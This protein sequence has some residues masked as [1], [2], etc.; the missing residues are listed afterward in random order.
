M[1]IRRLGWAGIEITAQDGTS[2]VVDYVRD[3]WLLPASQHPDQYAAAT[4]P[5][6]AALVT[7]LHDDHTDVGAI[8]SAV[9]PNGLLLR[10]AP[11]DASAEEA[12]LVEKPEA[13][14][15]DSVLNVRVVAEWERVEVGPFG[16]TAVPAVDGLGEA[17]VNWVV[18]AD[19]QRVFHGGDTMFHGFWWL[20]T[21]RAGPIDVA[22]LPINGPVVNDPFLDPPSM[23][24]AVLTP[25]EAAQAAALLRARTVVPIH[26]GAHSPPTYI[27]QENA[28]NRLI[29]AADKFGLSVIALA[30]GDSTDGVLAS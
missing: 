7:H 10:P 4:Q 24:P 3:T 22:V 14:L 9:G 20:I 21:R 27:E 1:K 18:E 17:Q 2:V 19:G 15:A 8:Q 25:E 23:L 30:P 12:V 6:A 29:E 5:A 11:F 16:I 13:A 28:V 26:F